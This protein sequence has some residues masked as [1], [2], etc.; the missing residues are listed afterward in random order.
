[1]IAACIFAGMST[2]R[3]R[4]FYGDSGQQMFDKASLL[5]RLK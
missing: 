3:I 1:M 2:D 5:N 4:K